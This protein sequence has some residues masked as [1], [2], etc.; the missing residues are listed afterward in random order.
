MNHAE[1]LLNYQSDKII[2]A[3]PEAIMDEAKQALA[4]FAD[5][6]PDLKADEA[7]SNS[8]YL[9]QSCRAVLARGGRC[10]AD[11]YHRLPVQGARL[12]QHASVARQDH[13]GDAGGQ[14]GR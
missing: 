2:A 6:F 12:V 4:R 13:C 5:V 1:L 10:Q 8:K 11:D 9:V 14:A 7:A 3:V